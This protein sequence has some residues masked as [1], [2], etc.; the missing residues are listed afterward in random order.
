MKDIF[1]YLKMTTALQNLAQ[2]I[3]VQNWEG[4]IEYH[5]SV[6]KLI[7]PVDDGDRQSFKKIKDLAAHMARIKALVLEQVAIVSSL[8]ETTH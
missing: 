1:E 7:N 6:E 2:V 3:A 8:T 4:F 5:E